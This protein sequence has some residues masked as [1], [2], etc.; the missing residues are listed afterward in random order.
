MKTKLSICVTLLF[1]IIVSAQNFQ[2]KATYK[3]SRK[4]KLK[5]G[6]KNST[7]SD[8]MKKQIEERLRKMNQK[9]FILQFNNF[10]SIYKEDVKLDAPKPKVGATNV[11]VMSFG[12]SGNGSIYYKNIKEKKYVNQTEIMGKRFLVKDSLP[13]YKWKLLPETKNIGKYTCYKATFSREVDN[14]TMTIENGVAKEVIKKSTVVTTAWYTPQIP[15]SNGPDNYQ[16][17]PGL[18][19]E[20]N[21][22]TTTIV[23]TE[24]ILDTSEKITIDEPV[25][26]KIVSQKEYDKISREKSKE[27]MN[28]FKGRNG[29]GIKIQIGG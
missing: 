25:K 14:T 26:G 6:G 20:V 28:R 16:G 2:G 3:T 27:M 24:I 19:L 9:T 18:V 12:G 8:D 15:I 1:S 4:S 7:M 21:D 22:G 17:L 5:I 11:R 10:S 29:N 23:C 13:Q